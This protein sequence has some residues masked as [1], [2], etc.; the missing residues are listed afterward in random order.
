MSGKQRK[1][2][3]GDKR[4]VGAWQIR[5]WYVDRAVELQLSCLDEEW[6]VWTGRDE[7]PY[8]WLRDNL[9]A[10]LDDACKVQTTN[11]TELEAAIRELV[12][13][14]YEWAMVNAADAGWAP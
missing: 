7:D 4:M 3:H 10:L 9:E 6:L 14:V 1:Q 2:W 12:A 13:A 11:R 5:A 8:G